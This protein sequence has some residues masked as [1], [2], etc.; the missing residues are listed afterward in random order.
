MCTT[1]KNCT[2]ILNV[3]TSI[4]VQNKWFSSL[5]FDVAVQG[6]LINNFIN[7]LQFYLYATT[8]HCKLKWLIQELKLGNKSYIRTL[9]TPFALNIYELFLLA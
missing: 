5:I 7:L 6:K 2:Y 3:C 8:Y 4:N 1:L 9:D